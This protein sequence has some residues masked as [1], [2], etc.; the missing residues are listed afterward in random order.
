MDGFV[1]QVR[2]KICSEVEGREKLLA[3]KI[4]GLWK[5]AGRRRALANF[6]GV[7]KGEH[8]FLGT[9]QHVQNERRYFAQVGDTIAVQVAQGAVKEKKWKLVQFYLLF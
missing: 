5:H 9:N 1:T 8:Y 4:N 2:C 3:P 6:G 7:K